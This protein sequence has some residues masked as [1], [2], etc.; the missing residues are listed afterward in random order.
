MHILSLQPYFGGS[1]KA[2]QIE[3]Q[4]HSRHQWTVLTLPPR[5][6]KWRMRHAAV[7][8]AE[9][10]RNEHANT[11]FDALFC[12][13]FLNLAEF[14]GLADRSIRDLP[15]VLY[16][17]ENQFAYPSRRYD[18]RDLHFGFTNFTSCLAADQVWF[19]SDFNHHSFFEGLEAA[20]KKWPDYPPLQAVECIREK[21]RIEPPGIHV[22]TTGTDRLIAIDPVEIVWAA[23]W[24]H[25]KN[26][27]LLLAALREFRKREIDFRISVIGESF[28][29]IP[30]EFSQIQSEFESQIDR[31]GYQS[32]DDYWFALQDTPVFVSTAD[33][34]FFGISAA[35]SIACGA[36]P[37]LPNRLAYPELVRVSR[38]SE[39]EKLFLYDGTPSD[40]AEKL[41]Y[42]CRH[43][44]T[45]KLQQTRMQLQAEIASDL[46]WQTRAPLMDD[47]IEG[48]CVTFSPIG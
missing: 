24:E 17:H 10:L 8:F 15:T 27:A 11:K 35:E 23:R 33:H 30:D 12:S 14:R 39:R 2:F 4:Q 41:E 36:F 26:P 28:R 37:L 29:R 42:F 6:W 25:D 48:I 9:Q 40:L 13:D 16:F 21:C 43:A 47:Q 18:E 45:E 22:P 5:H 20:C 38:D 19:N 31:W 3:W 7:H 32:S 1:H 44:F 46:G 34:E